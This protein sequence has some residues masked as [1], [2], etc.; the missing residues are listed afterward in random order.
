VGDFGDCCFGGNPKI[1]E[2]IAVKITTD[3][4]IDHSYFIRKI[5]GTF[6]LDSSSRRIDEDGIPKVFY[7]IEA[8][9]IR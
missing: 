7:S 8:D 1:T 6:R 5:G 4:R 3:D 2:V 9:Y